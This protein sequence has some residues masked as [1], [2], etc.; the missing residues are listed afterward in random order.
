MEELIGGGAAAAGDGSLIREATA[1]SFVRDVIEGSRE[2]PVLVDFQAEWCGPC[3]QLTPLLEKQVRANAGKLTL[4]K[5]DIDR[6]RE[7]AAQLRIQSVPTVYAFYQGRPVDAFQGALPESKLAEFIAKLLKN[8]DQGRSA[9][10]EL[11]EEAEAALEAGQE[12]LAERMYRTVLEMEA[13]HPGAAAGLSGLALA[14]GDRDEAARLLDEAAPGKGNDPAI[15]K[16]RAAIDL[17]GQAEAA[18]DLA[19]LEARLAATPDDLAVRHDL[20]LALA[21]AGRADEA[22]ELLL[23]ILRR[24]LDWNDGAARTQLLRLF[25]AAGPASPFSLRWRRRLSSLLFA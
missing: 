25:D 23:D 19:E 11:I 16:A 6:H 8:C 15:L 21:G 17:A 1:E 10:D 4:I 3:K 14:R 2:R 20:A 12:A 22:A 13:G 7:I 5:V 24:E 18:G 9:V